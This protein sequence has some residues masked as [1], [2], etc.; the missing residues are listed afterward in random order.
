MNELENAKWLNAIPPA[1]IKDNAAF[2]SNVIDTAMAG[3]AR[4]LVFVIALGTIDATM[5]VLKLMQSTVKTD[6]TTLGGTPALLKDFTTKP[7][8]ADGGKLWGLVIDL[9]QEHSRYLQLQATAGN[10]DAGT[11][12]AATAA[13]VGPGVPPTNAGFD[14]LERG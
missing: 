3:G 10:G 6:G 5:A 13:F 14:V 11:Y 4:W 12:L 7:T 2:V 1:V 8:D 9:K